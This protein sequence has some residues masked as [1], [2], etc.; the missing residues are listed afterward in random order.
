MAAPQPSSGATTTPSR[1][2]SGAIA[3][4]PRRG[5]TVA[6]L[7][8]GHS[9]LLRSA[10]NGRAVTRVGSR[11]EFGSRRVLAIAAVRKDWLGVTALERRNGRLSWIRRDSDA[12]RLE[13]TTYW[14]RADRSSRR[15][16]LLHGRRVVRRVAVAVGRPGSSTPTGRFAVTDKLRGRDHGSYYGCCILALSGTQPNLPAGW[17]GGNRLAV[18]G[19]NAPGSI[20]RAASAGCLR[21]GD[22]DLRVLMR[23]VPLGAPVF[24]RR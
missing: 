12:F 4:S 8:P 1:S 11:T 2:D 3:N 7:R 19:T 17:R 21:A 13:R 6:R 23:R 14:L 16:E 10:P 5:F 22:G 20:G 9:V 24:I 15:L 18:H